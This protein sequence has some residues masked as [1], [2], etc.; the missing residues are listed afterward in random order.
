[1]QHQS[2]Q[3]FV[4]KAVQPIIKKLRLSDEES[5][6]NKMSSTHLTTA[7]SAADLDSKALNKFSRQNAALGAETTAKLIKMKVLIVGMRGVGMETAKN[8]SLQGVGA[9]TLIDPHPVELRDLGV[10]FFLTEDDVAF[11]KRRAEAIDAT[12]V[13]IAS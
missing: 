12:I 7:T 3:D 4:D 11:K 2:S 6:S 8:L 9:I 10:N 1:M 5:Y 13:D